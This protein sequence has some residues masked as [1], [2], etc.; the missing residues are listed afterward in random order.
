VLDGTLRT[1]LTERLPNLAAGEVNEA[2]LE[3]QR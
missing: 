1:L 2:L 3:L